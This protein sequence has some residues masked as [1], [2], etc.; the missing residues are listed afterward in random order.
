V[1]HPKLKP[2][3][4]AR[5]AQITRDRLSKAFDSLAAIILS[6]KGA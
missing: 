3:E 6:F 5:V 1:A 4:Q 2:A